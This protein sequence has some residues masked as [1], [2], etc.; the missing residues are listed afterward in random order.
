MTTIEARATRTTRTTGNGRAYR[1]RLKGR[2]R[3]RAAKRDHYGVG[4]SNEPTGTEFA[5]P[6]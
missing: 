4:T 3:R 5:A 6:Y 2:I 1:N